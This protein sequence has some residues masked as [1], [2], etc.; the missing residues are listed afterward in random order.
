MHSGGLFKLDSQNK[1]PFDYAG[2]GVTGDPFFIQHTAL[3]SIHVIF[4]RFHNMIAKYL[5]K[6]HP[7][8]T[9]DNIFYEVR[10][11]VIA[12]WQHLIYDEWLPLVLGKEIRLISVKKR[13]KCE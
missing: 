3:I 8:W 11:I 12:V 1:L 4:Y 2:V 13:H 7:H 10:R 6:H 5:S 9:D